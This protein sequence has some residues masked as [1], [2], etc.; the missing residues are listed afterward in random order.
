MKGLVLKSLAIRARS[1]ISSWGIALF[2][3]DYRV[4]AFTRVARASRYGTASGSDRILHS[5]ALIRFA[6]WPRLSVSIR[7]LTARGSVTS[8]SFAT[9]AL[10]FR[11]IC[12]LRPYPFTNTNKSD[13]ERVAQN[14]TFVRPLH[15]VGIDLG[16]RSG[17]VAPAIRLDAFSVRGRRRLT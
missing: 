3:T 13:P 12:K 10:L 9:L 7:S 15:K 14:V 1:E 2:Q 6:F 11:P 5:T 17:G 8:S 4:H 16:I